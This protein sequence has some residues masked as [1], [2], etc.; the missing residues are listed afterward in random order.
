MI[1]IFALKDNS[2][3]MSFDFLP[4]FLWQRI[5]KEGY[6]TLVAIDKND[7]A[8]EIFAPI[9]LYSLTAI[10]PLTTVQNAAQTSTDQSGTTLL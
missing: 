1:E 6:Y 2:V 10:T 7:G 9:F 5:G 3:D 4:A 8:D